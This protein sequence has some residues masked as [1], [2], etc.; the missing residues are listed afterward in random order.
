M[1]G[2]EF[3][4]ELESKQLSEVITD[5]YDVLSEDLEILSPPD[6]DN[7]IFKYIGTS[8]Q[9]QYYINKVC[10]RR[11]VQRAGFGFVIQRAELADHFRISLDVEITD[12]VTRKD[13]TAVVEYMREYAFMHFDEPKPG[14]VVYTQPAHSGKRS[15]SDK[16]FVGIEVEVTDREFKSLQRLTKRI[17]DHARKLFHALDFAITNEN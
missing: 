1:E 6:N 14:I 3:S 12:E 11:D 10:R 13:S 9:A 16:R 4:R 8:P 17:L 5:I 2:P 15:W 7:G